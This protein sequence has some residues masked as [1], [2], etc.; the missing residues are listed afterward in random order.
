[1][2]ECDAS[3]AYAE[4]CEEDFMTAV[5]LVTIGRGEIPFRSVYWIEPVFA[6]N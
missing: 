1:M 4:T 3:V 2:G 5:G 6:M